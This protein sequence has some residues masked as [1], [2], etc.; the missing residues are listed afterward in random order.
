MRTVGSV[1]VF[2]IFITVQSTRRRLQVRELLLFGK[3]A[4]DGSRA[5]FGVSSQ[6]IHWV[7]SYDITPK[8]TVSSPVIYGLCDG[9]L[10][11][12]AARFLA[13]Q[14]ETVRQMEYNKL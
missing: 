9:H 13:S 3:E 10:G 8:E 1:G 6:D 2:H 5:R 4:N 14:L 11:T 12:N 7:S